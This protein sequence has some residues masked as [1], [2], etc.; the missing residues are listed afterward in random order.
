MNSKLKFKMAVIT[1]ATTA[2]AL[3]S[4]AHAQVG[5]VNQNQQSNGGNQVL[6]SIIGGVAGAALGD[7]IAPRGSNQQQQRFVQQGGF[8]QQPGFVQQQGGFVQQG[9][10]VQQGGFVQQ[11]GGF[12]QQGG[13][14]YRQ[15]VV[16]QQPVY[17][18]AAP[19]Y[20]G[21]TP[22]YGGGRSNV[23]VNLGFGTRGFGN[24]GFG[25]FGFGNRGFGNSLFIGSTFGNRGG[26][27]AGRFFMS[28]ALF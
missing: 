25:S 18:S 26:F 4:T 16:V 15:P 7:G 11:P 13:V 8:V 20:Y 6:G 9:G 28:A 2:I 22:Y 12:V 5:F 24:R 14:V 21:G 19:V 3:S 1:A 27:C 17:Y 10:V 23:S